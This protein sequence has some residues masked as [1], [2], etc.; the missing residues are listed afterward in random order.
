MSETLAVGSLTVA[1]R[2]SERR[3][4]LGLTV[5]RYGEVVLYAPIQAPAEELFRWAHR[6]LLWVHRKLAL[7][8]ALAPKV[9][10]PE[11]VQATT[12][13]VV[14]LTTIAAMLRIKT[15]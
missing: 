11:F 6:K 10:E 7:K 15:T 13:A 4:T 5:D 2:R 9:R 12:P 14:R 8:E 3:K 1:V